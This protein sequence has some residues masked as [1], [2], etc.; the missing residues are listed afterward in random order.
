M[1]VTILLVDDHHVV[2][3]GLRALLESQA[4]F[5]VVGEASGGM[6]AIQLTEKLHPQVVILDLMMP[7]LNGLEV[8]RQIHTHTRVLILSMYDNEGYVFEALRYGA[9]GYMLK[10]STA[11]DLVQAVR[12]VAEGRRYLGPPFSEL[13]IQTYI[14]K[15]KSKPLDP[16]DMLTN[17]ERQVLNLVVQGLSSN[18]VA[19]QLSISPR[20]VEIHRANLMHKLNLHSQSE[21]IRFAIKRGILPLEE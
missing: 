9:F 3:Q 10:D 2:R 5:N 14:E 8:T 13:A 20:T 11:V 16:Y 19:V 4:D 17:R 12:A 6:E 1:T 7:D 18:D 15:A 21:L